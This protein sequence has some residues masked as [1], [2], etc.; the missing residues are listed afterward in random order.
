MSVRACE[1]RRVERDGYRGP[2]WNEKKNAGDRSTCEHQKGGKKLFRRERKKARERK[3]IFFG[4]ER[5]KILAS[6]RTQPTKRLM[7]RR[8]DFFLGR[9]LFLSGVST[10]LERAATIRFFLKVNAKDKKYFL[11]V[12]AKRQKIHDD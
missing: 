12:N 7:Y 11:K 4:R 9:Y 2:P 10:I 3:K 1:I 8:E 6:T 5:K